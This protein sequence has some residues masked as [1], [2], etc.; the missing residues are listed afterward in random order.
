MNDLRIR[1]IPP[2]FYHYKKSMCVLITY[3][4]E[5]IITRNFETS[6]VVTYWNR[7]YVPNYVSYRRVST[8]GGNYTYRIEGRNMDMSVPDDKALLDFLIKYPDDK[9]EVAREFICNGKDWGKWF[10]Y[11]IEGADPVIAFIHC[12]A[13][14]TDKL[15]K[16]D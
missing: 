7:V 6:T 2:Y 1:L 5:E 10:I 15:I 16:E 14:E 12:S 11:N 4:D 8:L 13:V 9:G 3:R